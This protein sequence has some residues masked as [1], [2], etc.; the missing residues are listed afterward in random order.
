MYSNLTRTHAAL[1]VAVSTAFRVAFGP[2]LA[3]LLLSVGTGAAA[4]TYIPGKIVRP[5]TITATK[6]ILD[7]NGDGYTSATTTGY[8]GQDDVST[9]VNEIAYKPLYPFFA[10]PNSDLR[11]GADKRFTDYVPSTIDK[12]SYY[13]YYTGTNVL[14]RV[15][16][17][18][19]IPGA[20][21][22]SF[23]IDID[24]KFG[25]SGPLADPNYLPA[26]T[27][28][29]G[30]PGFEIEVD[31]FSQ[32]GS[33]TGIAVYNIDGKDKRTDF[34]L[35]YNVANWVDYSHVSMAATSDNGDPDY[36]VDFYIP[37]TAL[38]SLSFT[39]PTLPVT[40]S[41]SLRIIPTTVMAP[42]PAVGGPKSDIYGLPDGLFPN[43]NDEYIAMLGSMPAI[44]MTNFGSGGTG[45]SSTACTAPPTL[46]KISSAT[47]TATVS[48]TWTPN[49]TTGAILSNV[50]VTLYRSTDGGTTYTPF[51]TTATVTASSSTN[52]VNWSIASVPVANGNLYYA[53]AQ[54]PG[55]S[56]CFKS[57]TVTASGCSGVA[58]AAPILGC[59]TTTK[60][61][62]GANKPTVWAAAYPGTY[63]YASNNARNT[64][65]SQASSL[66]GTGTI[67]STN[68]TV[69]AF[70]ESG[71]APTV[72]WT[73]SAGCSGGS[74]LES[75]S[76]KIWYQD[77]NGCASN[78]TIGC[79]M[80]NGGNT[81]LA[82][83]LLTPAITSPANGV[84]TSTTTAITAS[85]SQGSTMILYVN[86]VAVSSGTASLNG[87]ST[88]AAATTGAYTFT[89]LNLSKSDSVEVFSEYGTGSAAASYCGKTSSQV[90]V[91][92]VTESPSIS[93]N[94][95]S[96]LLQP[97]S[98][99][100]IQGTSSSIGGTVTIYNSTATGTSL[101]TATVSSTGAW[102]STITPTSGQSYVA[103]VTAT[104]GCASAY[105]TA[106]L[107]N[108]STTSSSLCTGAAISSYTT[109]YL[110]GVAY[111][112]A[113]TTVTNSPASSSFAMNAFAT[114]VTVSFAT[115]SNAR[116][117][118][119]YEDG[120]FVGSTS[121]AANATT[122]VFSNGTTTGDNLG[123]YTGTSGSTSAG[124]VYFT[125]SEAS[126]ALQ[127]YLP[128][129]TCPNVGVVTCPVNTTTPTLTVA[130]CPTC[131]ATGTSSATV[132]SGGTVTFKISGV[133]VNT[134]YA[135]RSS[136]GT[137]YSNTYTVPASFTGTD[138]YLTSFPIS[139]STGSTVSIQAIATTVVVSN[140]VAVSCAATSTSATVTLGAATSLGIN[141][142]VYDDP[143]KYNI[144]GAPVSSVTN[145]LGTSRPLYVYLVN[146]S[147][148]IQ[149]G[150]AVSATGTY[151]FTG[152]TS[153]LTYKVVLDTLITTDATR[154]A[155][156]TLSSA[157]VP[158]GWT[159]KAEGTS[160]GAG[161][162]TANGV[163]TAGAITSSQVIDFGINGLPLATSNTASSQVNPGGSINVTV[164]SA[165][166]SGTDP[167]DVSSSGIVEYIRIASFPTNT[168]SITVTG[169]DKTDNTA[170]SV[171]YYA[172][173]LPSG[174]TSCA[175]FP[176]GGIYVG[177][178]TSGNPSTSVLL[179][180]VNSAV[181]MVVSYAT[182]DNGGK[183]SSLKTASQPVSTPLPVHL[184]TF[185]GEKQANSAQLVWTSASEESFRGY[186]VERS[187]DGRAFSEVGF[188]IAR[189]AVTTQR[190]NYNDNL[191][192]LT[193]PYVY[194]RLRL[195]DLNGSYSYSAV[196]RLALG[197]DGAQS[198]IVLGN[199]VTTGAI[200]LQVNSAGATLARI[201]VTDIGG[202]IVASRQL[203]LYTGSSTLSLALPAQLAK[204][205]Y[206]ITAELNGERF[207]QL[208]LIDK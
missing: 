142:T 2:F 18:S 34:T 195:V 122:A 52:T 153:G 55:E 14:F 67:Q 50:V 127:T 109:S 130:N 137:S 160:G 11:R 35:G 32:A 196:V 158:Y 5:S 6:A 136:T 71:T 30:N 166:F 21:G 112:G 101:G 39:A 43:P 179:D 120:N 110:N 170:T 80:G 207:S 165:T 51:A 149:S 134:I 79:A 38:S 27:G 114:T 33:Q 157:S 87:V 57:S 108:S 191:V 147:N 163:F 12:A 138:I 111:T 156:Q 65:S 173:T 100:F 187:T 60:G 167:R 135:L 178:N 19:I 161:D 85:G 155:G 90:G 22:Y 76:Y 162:G 164:P 181:T 82:G 174:C 115:S 132:P 45:Q 42:L 194:Y 202:R 31:L 58:L 159:Y 103:T 201:S 176:S 89:G 128:E 23:L 41:T 192:G 16:M 190:Y 188:V 203:Q 145:A 96:S 148:V 9:G 198:M 99:G 93:T 63:I 7:P 75:G 175:L 180:P 169:S 126:T 95:S 171:T 13:M 10:E 97:S 125:I 44:T 182:V 56:A 66:A 4:Q 88:L 84:L 117:I 204:G 124:N 81:P 102:T 15:R 186:S 172:T 104:S 185:T 177:T 200:R 59:T 154:L 92:C 69:Q 107:Y 105:S 70:T 68:G 123:F 54:A 197:S 40:T 94:S 47:S 64:A 139:G 140:N 62:D 151:S 208:I 129:T 133:S 72:A 36:Y 183:E 205:T 193:T 24:G 29:G 77:A 152:L 131:T 8:S 121:V 206:T 25:Y 83:T 73:F 61:F 49:N 17:G 141:G 146:S 91:K 144:T 53:Q 46:N 26:N 37:F 98:G 48:G 20:K 3:L 86:G 119:L 106:L 168:N 116:L 78:P 113:G 143:Y 189:G 184:L 74:P 1:P 199:P 28:I 118:S 150:T